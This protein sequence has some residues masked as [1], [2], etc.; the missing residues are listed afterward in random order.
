MKTV[1]FRDS[2][3]VCR[4]VVYLIIVCMS[5]TW[6]ITGLSKMEAGNMSAM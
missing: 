6:S 4:L 5:A 1:V 2:L 3:H